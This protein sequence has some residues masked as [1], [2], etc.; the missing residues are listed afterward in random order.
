VLALVGANDPWFRAPVLSG[1]C[2]AFMQDRM[3][4]SIVYSEPDY[5]NDKHW[6]SADRDVQREITDF[7]DRAISTRRKPDAE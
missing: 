3:S 7:I 2:G 1:D 6:L 5:L 4:R